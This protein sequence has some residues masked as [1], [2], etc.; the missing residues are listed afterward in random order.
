[1][2]SIKQDTRCPH[3]GTVFTAASDNPLNGDVSMCVGCGELAVLDD[4]AP[5]G[6][7]RLD[8]RE[9]EEARRDHRLAVA[10]DLWRRMKAEG[11][12]VPKGP[13]KLIN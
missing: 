9:A 6:Q 12:V 11:R 8:A 2:T 5:G 7:R 10:Q 4:A 1:M 3:C 13:S